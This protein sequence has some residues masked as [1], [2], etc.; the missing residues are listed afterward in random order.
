M[1]LI[2]SGYRGY[3]GRWLSWGHPGPQ[4]AHKAQPGGC[5]WEAP[6]SLFS[7]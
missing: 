3:W 5:E 7:D 6:V 2:G 4:R 1:T